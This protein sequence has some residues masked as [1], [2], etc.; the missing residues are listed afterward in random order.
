MCWCSTSTLLSR[1]T[2]AEPGHLFRV[3]KHWASP[4]PHTHY[5]QKQQR[6]LGT[7]P[8]LRC[9]RIS[10]GKEHP[11]SG[12]RQHLQRHCRRCMRT[13]TSGFVCQCTEP[14]SAQ[15]DRNA[16]NSAPVVSLAR[17]HWQKPMGSEPSQTG[18]E[19][20]AYDPKQ[21]RQNW[22]FGLA[23]K[24]AYV[25]RCIWQ[26]IALQHETTSPHPGAAKLQASTSVTAQLAHCSH[27]APQDPRLPNRQLVSPSVQLMW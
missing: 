16:P 26:L 6:S 15:V 17:H 7:N 3:E 24:D 23:L 4:S 11:N 21:A 8:E 18:K 22:C 9:W 10:A 19:W 2:G 14:G 13:H 12:R 20:E 1:S 25:I 5:A 27:P